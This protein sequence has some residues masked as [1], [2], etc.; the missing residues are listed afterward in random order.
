[1]WMELLRALTQKRAMQSDTYCQIYTDKELKRFDSLSVCEWTFAFV[2]YK[3]DGWFGVWLFLL[4]PCDCWE[5]RNPEHLSD[6]LGN[7]QV[8][9]LV[10]IITT[11]NENRCSFQEL[12]SNVA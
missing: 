10:N 6:G 11:P 4:C 3:M 9:M 1:M 8:A 5:L 2:V 12:Y 7:R